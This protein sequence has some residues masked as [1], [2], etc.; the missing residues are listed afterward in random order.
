MPIGHGFSLHCH[1]RVEPSSTEKKRSTTSTIKLTKPRR[2]RPRLK[3]APFPS[4]RTKRPVGAS[5]AAKAALCASLCRRTQTAQAT[6]SPQCTGAPGGNSAPAVQTNAAHIATKSSLRGAS[7]SLRRTAPHA[8]QPEIA[9][10]NKCPSSGAT[11]NLPPDRHLPEK[12]PPRRE[13]EPC[14]ATGNLCAFV[15]KIRQLFVQIRQTLFVSICFRLF[16][17]KSFFWMARAPRFSSPRPS[18]TRPLFSLCRFRVRSARRPG[19]FGRVHQKHRETAN[20]FH[21]SLLAAV[22]LGGVGIDGHIVEG[23]FPFAGGGGGGDLFPGATA[24][25]L[26]PF[27]VETSALPDAQ[28]G[29]P[30]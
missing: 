25:S 4:R 1:E 18:A 13:T 24:I 11:A 23:L 15:R 21:E 5:S 20:A 7:P 3:S 17:P 29:R 30:E 19:L 12:A 28:P 14:A 10:L 9:R 26:R 16:R 27:S 8:Y 2:H 22:A 6:P